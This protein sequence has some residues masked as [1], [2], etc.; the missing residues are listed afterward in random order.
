MDE[1]KETVTSECGAQAFPEVKQLHTITYARRPNPHCDGC[2]WSRRTTADK[3][4]LV[5]HNP[6][7]RCNLETAPV[8]LPKTR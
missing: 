3:F 2:H 7:R 8:G 5:S 4:V 6:A 1:I